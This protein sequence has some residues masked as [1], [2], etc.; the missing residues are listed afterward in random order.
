MWEEVTRTER[1]MNV[2]AG[3]ALICSLNKN[4]QFGKK[5]SHFDCFCGKFYLCCHFLRRA[6]MT[7]LYHARSRQNTEIQ[8]PDQ[9]F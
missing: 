3:P 6:V 7:N 8:I 2:F 4:E 5:K 1:G 9:L